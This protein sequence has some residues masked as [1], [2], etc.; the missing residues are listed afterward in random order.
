VSDILLFWRDGNII[1]AILAIVVL[2]MN[3]LTIVV[4]H[5]NLIKMI[6][7]AGSSV[8]LGR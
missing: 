5:R 3:A 2:A 1:E 8:A 6:K 7:L 4:V